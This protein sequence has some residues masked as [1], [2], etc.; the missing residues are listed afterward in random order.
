MGSRGVM[1]AAG[2]ARSNCEIV[3]SQKSLA[4]AKD[5][6]ALIATEVWVVQMLSRG[7]LGRF[8][9]SKGVDASKSRP[10]PNPGVIPSST[11]GSVCGPVPNMGSSRTAR[12]MP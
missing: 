4:T 7:P 8:G 6:L 2:S 11:I 12:S 1:R 5:P 9:S 3:P 10:S